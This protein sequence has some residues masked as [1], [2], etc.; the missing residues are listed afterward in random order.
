MNQYATQI[1]AINPSTGEITTYTGPNVPGINLQDAN[2][3]CQAN[4]LG[5]C[6]VL[7]VLI[8]EIAA[9][10]NTAIQHHS[11]MTILLTTKI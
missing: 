1:K 4:G 3:Y 10:E 7:G 5:Y 2:N 8:A 11:T 9:N 6:K